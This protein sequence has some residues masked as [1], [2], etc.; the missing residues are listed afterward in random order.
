MA[1]ICEKIACKELSPD[2]AKHC[3][4]W[5][6]NRDLFTHTFEENRGQF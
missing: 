3:I 1:S 2:L 5:A 6:A 4:V